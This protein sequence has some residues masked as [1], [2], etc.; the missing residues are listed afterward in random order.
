LFNLLLKIIGADY[1][2]TD[3]CIFRMSSS[4]PHFQ[5][6][7]ETRR[8]ACKNSTHTIQTILVIR[9]FRNPAW[10]IVSGK[11]RQNWGFLFLA[12]LCE[13]FS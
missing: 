7:S 2:P 10:R 12:Y 5:L 11:V 1:C 9:P 6:N 3:L 4:L 13:C 8:I